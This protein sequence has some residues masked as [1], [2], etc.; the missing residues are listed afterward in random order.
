MGTQQPPAPRRGTSALLQLCSQSYRALSLQ[1][2][3]WSMYKPPLIH[4]SCAMKN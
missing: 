2:K 1:G 3:Q 4:A